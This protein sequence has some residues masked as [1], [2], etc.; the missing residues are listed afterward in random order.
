MQFFGT[1]TGQNDRVEIPLTPNRTIDVGG[2][3]TLE[4]WMQATPGNASGSCV[5]GGT[6]WVNGN[7][8]IDR[9]VNGP[10]DFGD[11]G[12]SLF[13]A[14]GRIAFRGER[15]YECDHAVQH[16]G[17]ERRD[18]APRRGHVNGATGALAIFIDGVPSGSATGPAGDV[19]LPRRSG[20][21]GRRT[22]P[23]SCS[24]PRSTTPVR[25]SRA[26]AA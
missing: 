13:A 14:D 18:L 26:T 6:S 21:V 1:G 25:S 17:R 8:L 16:R 2:D 11:Y 15:W 5:A 10:G 22:T 9:D 7:I 3:F 20:D 12:V 19:E 4:W 24:G 23:S